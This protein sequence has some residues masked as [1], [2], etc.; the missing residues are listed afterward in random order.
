M[1]VEA[2]IMKYYTRGLRFA[3]IKIDGER[4]II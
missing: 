3:S 4:I 1:Y 2:I